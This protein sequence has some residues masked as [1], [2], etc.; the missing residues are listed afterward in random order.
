V[1]AEVV[2]ADVIAAEVVWEEAEVLLEDLVAEGLDED[3]AALAVA[4]FLDAVLPL[5]ALIPGPLGELAEAADGPILARVVQAL[6]AL[7]RSDPDR[8]AERRARRTARK[9]EREAKREARRA[10]RRAQ[11]EGHSER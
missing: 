1:A 2:V 10:E 6:L 3:A 9:A 11:R 7:F 5:D 8:K 4:R